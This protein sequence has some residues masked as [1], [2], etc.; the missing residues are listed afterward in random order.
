MTDWAKEIAIWQLAGNWTIR[1]SEK[2]S[3][4]GWQ[5]LV[6]TIDSN[7]GKWTIWKPIAQ[8]T[9][10]DVQKAMKWPPK[11]GHP[12]GGDGGDVSRPWWEA[13]DD[14]EP[15]K[16]KETMDDDDAPKH[17]IP[18]RIPRRYS[19]G[20]DVNARSASQETSHPQSSTT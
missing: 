11:P 4:W 7:L 6:T 2:Q 10:E 15:P 16:Y 17:K 8:V 20:L 1:E 14:D 12:N 18:R 3:I 9:K 5:E 19:K 13:M